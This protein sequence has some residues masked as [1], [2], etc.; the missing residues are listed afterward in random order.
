MNQQSMTNRSR[1]YSGSDFLDLPGIENILL[2]I[3]EYL[4][5]EDIKNLALVCHQISK[6]TKDYITY[7]LSHLNELDAIFDPFKKN[8]DYNINYTPNSTLEI[9]PIAQ[10]L[11]I[12]INKKTESTFKILSINRMVLF[13][14]PNF[15]SLRLIFH[16]NQFESCIRNIHLKMENCPYIDRVM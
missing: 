1:I 3:V 13:L 12:R 7:I 4:F 14:G 8:I 16:E 6:I 9:I 5:F 11:I 2:R 10:N 15:Q